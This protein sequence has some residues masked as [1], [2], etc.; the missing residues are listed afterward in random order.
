[1]SRNDLL[2]RARQRPFTP[3]RLIVSEGAAHDIRHPEQLMV[4]RDSAVIGL[5]GGPEQDFYDTTVL[6]DLLHIVRLEPL[7]A[8]TPTSGAGAG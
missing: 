7:P 1:M 5:P 6:V 4:A 3:F 2:E 8:A